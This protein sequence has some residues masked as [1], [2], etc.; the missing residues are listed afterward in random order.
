MIDQLYSLSSWLLFFTIN[1]SQ[2]AKIAE[3]YFKFILLILSKNTKKLKKQLSST[4][5]TEA[6][7]S[8]ELHRSSKRFGDA[9]SL[10]D[11]HI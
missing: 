8:R 4:V 5:V 11:S 9:A 7:F 3:I 2:T 6:Q 10:A 1:L